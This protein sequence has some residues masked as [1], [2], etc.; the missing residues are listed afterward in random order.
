MNRRAFT[1]DEDAVVVRYIDGEITGSAGARL[2][3]RA[4]GCFHARARLLRGR[5]ADC[6]HCP[7]GPITDQLQDR[8]A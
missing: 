3:G 8:A 6:M 2:T 1:E 7:T 5:P 4:L